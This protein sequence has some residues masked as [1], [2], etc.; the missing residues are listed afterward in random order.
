MVVMMVSAPA[1]AQ[2]TVTAQQA[3]AASTELAKKLANPIADLVSVPF[4]FNWAPGVGP[5]EAT[6]F[7]LN[8]QPVMPFSL[9]KDWNLITRV[10]VPFIGQ[11]VLVAGGAPASGIGD[12]LSSFFFSPARGKITW[13]VG[14][15]VSLPSTS[16]PTL[17]SGKWSM[18][19]TA[20]MLKQS[21]P[22]TV[23]VLWN[24]VWSVAGATSRTDVSQMFLQPFVS[25]TTKK[26]VTLSLNTETVVNWEATGHQW[27]VPIN[28]GVSKL[29]SFGPFPASYQVAVGFFAA[30]PDDGPTWQLRSAV[31]VLLPRRR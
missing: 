9:N 12:I 15:V 17:G 3:A 29:S 4:Q 16:E 5:D 25:Y 22:W 24:Q 30:G 18:G 27:T 11:P 20:L 23:G 31:V 7:I 1:R 19:A 21:G 26:A 28:V 2:E 6:R 14:P 8:V 10:I 13:G